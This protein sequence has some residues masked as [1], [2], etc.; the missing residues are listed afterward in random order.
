MAAQLGATGVA[1]EAP[2]RTSR[3]DFTPWPQWLV[4][5]RWLVNTVLGQL[6]ERYQTVRV[7]ARDLH[8]L[9]VRLTR[10]LLSHTLA[11]LLCH[12][13]SLSLLTFDHLLADE[14]REPG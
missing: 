6:A 12:E 4:N 9:V 14:T 1:L 2:R 5:T 7:W 13:G 10:K 3:T 11:A 8:H